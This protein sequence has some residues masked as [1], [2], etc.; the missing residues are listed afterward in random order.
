MKV[1]VFS[2]S[3]Q[4]GR[5]FLADML[6]K[7]NVD[8]YGYARPTEHGKEF[9]SSVAEKRGIYLE[10]PQN[11]NNENN[12]FLWFGETSGVGHDLSR[13]IDSDV[14]Y[15]AHPSNF[16]LQTAVILKNAGII[17]RKIPLILAPPRSFA[18]PYLW[19]ILGEMYPIVSFSTCPYSCKA[20][21]VDTAYIKRRK[22]AWFASLEG[23]FSKKQVSN[24]E[25]LF[26]Q[27]IYNHVPLTTT[28]G[29][30]GAVFHPAT[31]LLNYETIKLCEKEGHPFSFYIDGIYKRPDVGN[32]LESID[33]VRL[34]I[35]NKL[36]A[37]TFGLKESPNEEYWAELM[38]SLYSKTDLT[39]D[40][41]QLRKIRHD[42]LINISNAVPSAQHWLDYTYGVRRIAGEPLHE[43]IGR[44]PT[45]QKMSVPQSRY[46][47]EDIPSSLVPLSAMAKRLS[48]NSSPL[49]YVI[50]L[51]K[52]YYNIKDLGAE[53]RDLQKFS[54][55]YLIDYLHGKF[56]E[57][58]N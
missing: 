1:G 25:S 12:S 22:R 36:G 31:Y 30:I 47:T 41:Q 3:S 53:W 24:I 9:I 56:F 23:R 33:Q 5:A 14:I 18:T 58:I 51:Y 28:I 2:V 34:Q 45:Y 50:D 48:I 52:K 6:L 46:V 15:I 29:N 39:E 16:L 42:C 19:D 27:V 32:F 55:N 26:P 10:R 44:T 38:T 4:S 49:D 40:I 21:K 17:E 11:K 37:V 7:G 35:A 57:L 20:P 43:A 54:T 8:V 13:L